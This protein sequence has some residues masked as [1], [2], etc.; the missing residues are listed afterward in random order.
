MIKLFFSDKEVI[1]PKLDN[2][3]KYYDS[4]VNPKKGTW[5]VS[6]GIDNL[7]SELKEMTKK[8]L[9]QLQKKYDKKHKCQMKYYLLLKAFI[10]K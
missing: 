4:V 8:D 10:K 7:D 1:M 9:E 3:K 6:T 2:A 5:C